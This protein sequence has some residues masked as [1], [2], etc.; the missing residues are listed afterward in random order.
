MRG[1]PEWPTT[2]S[3]PGCGAAYAGRGYCVTHYSQWAK[4][5]AANVEAVCPPRGPNGRKQQ[6]RLLTLEERL[7]RLVEYDTNGGCWLWGGSIDR[8]GYGRA[9]GHSR[10]SV[11]VHRLSFEHFVGPLAEG[12][13][14][15]H[16]CRVLSCLNPAHLEQVTPRENVLRSNGPAALNARKEVCAKG[17]PYIE[18][19]II[20]EG[21]KRVCRACRNDYQRRYYHQHEKQKRKVRA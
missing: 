21:T 7:L 2:C 15:D 5:G 4:G 17:H 19:N 10:R 1:S 18:P 20:W 16:L 12:Y 14:I 6:R 8:A 13:E 9:M 11:G 3:V